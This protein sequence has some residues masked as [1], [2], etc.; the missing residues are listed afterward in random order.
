MLNCFE[1]T[2]IKI[3]RESV[4]LGA[5]IIEKVINI[6]AL[7]ILSNC[8]QMFV[9]TNLIKLNRLSLLVFRKIDEMYEKNGDFSHFSVNF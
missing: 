6:Q 4:K 5:P 1:I 7:R 2:K 8:L 9:L 3:F